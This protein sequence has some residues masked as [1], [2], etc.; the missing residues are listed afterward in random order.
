ME[1]ACKGAKDAGGTTVGILPGYAPHAANSYVDCVIPTG[2]GQARNALVAAAGEALIALAASSGVLSEVAL[3][4]RL[5]RPVILIGGWPQQ[6]LE[7]LDPQSENTRVRVVE[8][9]EEA[10]REALA[11]LAST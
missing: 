7:L 1:A 11:L 6:L 9:P 4:V 5:S 3:A 8:Q 2:M 10:V